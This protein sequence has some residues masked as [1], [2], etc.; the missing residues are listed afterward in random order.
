MSVDAHTN[1]LNNYTH[2]LR[3]TDTNFFF[4]YDSHTYIQVLATMIMFLILIMTTVM[5]SEMKIVMHKGTIMTS[6][7]KMMIMMKMRMTMMM[8]A[9]LITTHND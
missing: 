4:S 3:L 7:R 1:T 5:I 8:W 6:M 9:I 2:S